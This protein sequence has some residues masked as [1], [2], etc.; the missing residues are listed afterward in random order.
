MA[1]KQNLPCVATLDDQ[2]KF[3]PFVKPLAGVFYKKAEGWIIE[4]LTSR[5]FVFRSE[6]TN[7]S[8][9]FCYRCNTPLYFNAIPAW[10]INIQRIKPHLVKENKSIN[11]YPEYLKYGRFGK[12]WKQPPD[13]N[14]S[15]SR[16]WGTPMPIW[17]NL[18]TKKIRIIGSVE[19]LKEW[20]VIPNKVAELKDLH[21]EFLDEI[22]VWIDDEKP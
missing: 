15:R 5:N 8:Y 13:W 6:K 2:G 3:L 10:Y 17:K 22:E 9:P 1:Q 16:Y 7:H 12:V 4:D 19:E 21:R 11:W 20:A 14:V 18:K